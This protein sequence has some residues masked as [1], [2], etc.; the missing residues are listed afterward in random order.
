MSGARPRLTRKKTEKALE[1]HAQPQSDEAPEP[2][3]AEASPR[4]RPARLTRKKGLRR[5][6]DDSLALAKFGKIKCSVVK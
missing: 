2:E 5:P 6:Y 1:A 4:E 3:Q